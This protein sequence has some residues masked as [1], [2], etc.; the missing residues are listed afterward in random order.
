MSK[1]KSSKSK[2]PKSAKSAGG[3]APTVTGQ[4][5]VH[6]PS[7]ILFDLVGTSAKTGF[8]DKV[9]MEYIKAN[10]QVYLENEWDDKLVQDD[11][12]KM[13]EVSKNDGGPAILDSGSVADIQKSVAEYV[14]TATN[15]QKCNDPLFKFR[16]HMWF[17]GYSKNKLVTPIYT[18]VADNMN[19]WKGENIKLYVCSNSW[20]EVS[21]RLL[22]Q[23]THGNLATLVTDFFDSSDGPMNQK[24]TFAKI[25][26]R[27]GQKAD[28]VLFL[29]K[30]GEEA[31]V[32]F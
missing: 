19:K 10:V 5:T 26:E 24:A 18:D 25:T 16:F 3:A 9:L 27:I 23:T 28:Q 2:L 12:A 13:R 32:S 4:I 17:H 21:R 8:V 22:A 7:A 31:R 6:K 14:I 29:T 15:K 30:Y 11:V 20:K 1:N